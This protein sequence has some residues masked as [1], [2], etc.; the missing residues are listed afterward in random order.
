[1]NFYHYTRSHIFQLDI[2]RKYKGK[3]W[4]P[5]S[6]LPNALY[7]SLED[8]WMKHVYII[9]QEY[10][11]DTLKKKFAYAHRIDF[12]INNLLE[13]KTLEDIHNINESHGYVIQPSRF[14]P[15]LFDILGITSN[16]LNFEDIRNE[17][18]GIL[19]NPYFED[20]EVQDYDWYSQICCSGAILWNLKDLNV[21]HNN[22][23][24][25][26]KIKY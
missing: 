3:R 10:K 2:D 7:L 25:I 16:G 8:E 23:G 9:A 12:D 15:G 19:I 6:F 17:Y 18:N 21:V 26:N 4:N 13:L 14:R 20:E 24:A 11:D 5:N 1:M 22:N